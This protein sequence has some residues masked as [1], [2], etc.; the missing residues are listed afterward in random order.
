MVPQTLSGLSPST[1]VHGLDAARAGALLLGIVFHGVESFT[2]NKAFVAVQDTQSS[3]LL[4][5]FYYVGHIFRMQVFFLMAGYF[6]HLLYRRQGPRGF[7]INRTKRLA[8]PFLLFWCVDFLLVAA[9]RVWNIQRVSGLSVSQAFARLP[10]EFKLEQGVPLMHLWF[11]YLLFFFCVGAFLV[12]ALLSRQP[13]TMHELRLRTR[14]ALA[15]VLARWWGS[16]ALA[17]LMVGPMLAMKQGLGVDTP[18]RSLWPLAAPFILYGLYFSLGWLL[19]S[20]PQA[21]QHL[22]RF[23]TSNLALGLGLVGVLFALKLAY[24]PAH[25]LSSAWLP[26]AIN[27]VYAFA[28][29]LLACAFIGYAL[30]YCSEPNAKIRY[31]SDSAYWGYLAHFPLI[32]FFQILVAPYNWHWS[33]KLLLILGPTFGILWLTYQVGVRN[34]K[35]GLLLNGRTYAPPTAR[36]PRLEQ[37]SV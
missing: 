16:L 28:S 33:V 36:K 37:A 17:S 35:L 22:S 32:I 9:L 5:A 34:T 2:F 20:Q 25:P 13:D 23:R 19:R 12:Q 26:S 30:K 24:D 8:L 18:D 7:L 21:L 1:R 27:L 14:R 29:M 4:S 31:L 10:P 11:L 3:V 15:W 6:A